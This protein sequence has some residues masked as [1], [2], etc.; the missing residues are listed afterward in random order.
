MERESLVAFGN[1]GDEFLQLLHRPFVNRHH[2]IVGDAVGC[3]IKIVDIAHQVADRISDLAIGI[4]QTAD[5]RIGASHIF[6]IIDGRNP[7]PEDIRA[8]FM[9][10]FKGVDI[11]A[12]RLGLLHSFF[13]DGKAVRQNR[14]KR[15]LP[16]CAE[17]GQKRKLEP[18]AMLVG[19]FEIQIDRHRPAGL[20]CDAVPTAARF[21]PDIEN[22][23]FLVQVVETENPAGSLKFS[24]RISL[25]ES[26][27]QLS[28][29]FFLKCA[30]TASTDS[31]VTSDL[32]SEL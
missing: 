22:I 4:L 10:L 17:C 30:A 13:I 2:L 18:A 21:E 23:F 16:C 6:L 7:Q 1:F 29:P 25:G 9:D 19:A 24:P 3:G 31:F 8:V 20:P 11:I 14:L 27:N 26:V 12:K 32:P 5:E 15:L 28:E